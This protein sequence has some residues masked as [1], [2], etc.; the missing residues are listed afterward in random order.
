M[1]E[2]KGLVVGEDQEPAP[3][4]PRDRAERMAAATRLLAHIRGRKKLLSED[5]RRFTRKLTGAPKIDL[6]PI[7]EEVSKDG[8]MLAREDQAAV[9]ALARPQPIA[10]H[11]MHVATHLEPALLSGHK[12]GGAVL[13]EGEVCLLT[14]AGGAGK[15]SLAAGLAIEF[16]RQRSEWHI[17]DFPTGGGPVLF[18]THEDSPARVARR[19]RKSAGLLELQEGDMPPV[20]VVDLRGN[21]IFGPSD[22]RGL[23][24]Q[25]PA[26]LAAW[27]P[28]WAEAESAKARLVVIDPAMSSYVG[29]PNSIPAVREFVTAVAYEARRLH[30]GVLMITHSN[31]AARQAKAEVDPYDS[32]QV[33]GTAAWS[34]GVRGVLVLIRHAHDEYELS[35][36]KSNFGRDKVSLTV[37]PVQGD[38]KGEYVG[39]EWLPEDSTGWHHRVVEQNQNNGNGK[40]SKSSKGTAM[41]Y[42]N[43]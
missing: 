33:G 9:E 26:P 11:F 39:F 35:I 16:A 7:L 3:T 22:D 41:G 17:F 34:D 21:P 36:L 19:L 5:L 10:E 8:R 32:K 40:R 18:A 15:S 4:I 30:L 2:N 27:E 31:K 42:G 1:N 25:R 13:T 14:G 24:N 29:E 23:Y 20:Y 12:L 6:A 28:L 38:G 37:K 43:A